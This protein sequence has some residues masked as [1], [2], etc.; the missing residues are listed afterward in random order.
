VTSPA[1]VTAYFD[2]VPEPHRATLR[3]VHA[4]LARLLPDAD[5]SLAYGVPAFKVGGKGVAGVGWYKGH[6]SYF[7][8]SGSI[9]TEL[10]DELV[11]YATSKGA[12]RFAA[13]EPLPDALVARL[14]QARRDEIARTGR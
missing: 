3:A 13:D 6:C 4:T 1:E 5:L 2:A 9:T 7:P 12:I 10:A 11:G 8:M 14:V